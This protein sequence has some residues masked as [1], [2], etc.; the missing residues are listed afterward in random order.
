MNVYLVKSF[1]LKLL[2]EEI[3]KIIGSSNNVIKFNYDDVSIEDIIEEC[4]YYSL[5]PEKKYVIINDFKLDNEAKK[6]EKY[7]SNPNPE[8]VLILITAKIDKRSVIFKLINSI[9]SVIE[10]NEL[11]SSELTDR[12]NNY[13]QENQITISYDA[14]FKLIDNNLANYDLIISE[15]DK[16]SI[17]H[18]QIDLDVINKFSFKLLSAENFDL[19]EAIIN[20]DKVKIDS[21]LEDFIILKN[22]VVPFVSLLAGQYRLLYAVKMMK[23]SVTDIA[24]KLNVHPY[25]IKLAIEK[26]QI[27]NQDE[28]LNNILALSDLDV[29]LK[30]LNVN[31]YSLL[32]MFLIKIC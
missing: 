28:I 31:Q 8:T 13:C 16:I 12:I 32:K 26:A 17:I 18:Q 22:E 1:S 29:N 15:I 21:S 19:S 20:K 6:L 9:G 2:K 11:K 10:L 5:L 3:N 25:R 7:L 14:L 23:G 27:Y 24:K 4:S 30:T